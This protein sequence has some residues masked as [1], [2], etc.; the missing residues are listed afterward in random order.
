MDQWV[1]Y[2]ERNW[3][4]NIEVPHKEGGFRELSVLVLNGTSEL[5]QLRVHGFDRK[6]KLVSS[7]K[8]QIKPGEA[9]EELRWSNV[10][11]T[12]Q[13]KSFDLV[14]VVI[15]SEHPLHVDAVTS[16]AQQGFEAPRCDKEKLDADEICPV[17]KKPDM[18]T[19]RT[20][21]VK[22]IDCAAEAT[23]H[24]WFCSAWRR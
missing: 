23:R 3:P 7:W 10:N 4:N 2:K 18:Y 24:G 12:T 22:E 15:S 6:G 1:L 21:P 11:W 16:T 20:L 14:T 9:R 8:T 19:K 17:Y 5:T 13:V